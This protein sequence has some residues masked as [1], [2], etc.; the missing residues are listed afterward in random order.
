MSGKYIKKK[1]KYLSVWTHFTPII[2]YTDLH[3]MRNLLLCMTNHKNP[4]S[5]NDVFFARYNF[6]IPV[7]E[8]LLTCLVS[9][10]LTNLILLLVTLFTLFVCTSYEVAN[11][12][13]VYFLCNVRIRLFVPTYI[14]FSLNLF[15]F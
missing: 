9:R 7:Y 6:S 3:D 10:K 11:L 13:N 2:V 5:N 12:I 1:K 15:Y 4:S 8:Y 14:F